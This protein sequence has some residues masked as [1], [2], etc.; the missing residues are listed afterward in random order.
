MSS[1]IEKFLNLIPDEHFQNNNIKKNFVVTLISIILA[2]IILLF[3]G[4]F[5]WNNCFVKMINIAK[6]IDSIFMLFGFSILMRL[7]FT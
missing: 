6:P 2:E 1:I 5:L 4:K 7:I 3:F